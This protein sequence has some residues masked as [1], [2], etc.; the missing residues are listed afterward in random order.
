MEF[1][2]HMRQYTR[3]GKKDNICHKCGEGIETIEHIFF[4]CRAVAVQNSLAIHSILLEIDLGGNAFFL[5]QVNKHGKLFH[6]SGMVYRMRDGIYGIGGK[7]SKEHLE[8][9]KEENT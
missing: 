3:T 6:C 8:E 2:Q 1:S 5:S 9:M 7:R 4:F